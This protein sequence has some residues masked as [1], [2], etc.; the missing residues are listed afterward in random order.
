MT[1]G[2]FRNNAIALGD[3]PY[4][5]CSMNA[6]EWFGLAARGTSLGTGILPGVSAGTVG[7]V[8]DVYDDLIDGIDGLIINPLVVGMIPKIPSTV[9]TITVEAVPVNQ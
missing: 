8:V 5:I 3:F 4:K 7:I 1:K 6:K 2:H 9:P